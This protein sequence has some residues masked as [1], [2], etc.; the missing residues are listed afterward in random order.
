MEEELISIIIPVYNTSQYLD[1]C[2]KSVINQTYKNIE[3]IIINDGSTD[4]SEQIALNY[5]QNNQKIKVKSIKHS[6][7]A[8]ARN[9]GLKLATGLYV[10]FVDSDDYIEPDMFECLYKNKKKYNADISMIAFRKIKNNKVIEEHKTK[11]IKVL[12]KQEF[13][14]EYLRLKEIKAHFTNKLFSRDLFSN[15]KFPINKNYEDDGIILKIADKINNFVLVD[16][17][18]YN[19]CL[20]TN[21]ITHKDDMKTRQDFYD[22]TYDNYNFVLKRYSN[23]K[24]YA[25]F[26]LIDSLISNYIASINHKKILSLIESEIPTMKKLL[27]TYSQTVLNELTSFKKC[28]LF[29]ILWNKKYIRENILRIIEEDNSI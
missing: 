20:R 21:S 24:N 2:L 13:I 8:N 9:I 28:I 14:K 26:Y 27:Q 15:I 10:G 7:V 18:L 19:Y 17:S 11:N 25:A 29:T 23:L 1:R 22:I 5:A 3:I 16:I 6:G 12:N 4:N